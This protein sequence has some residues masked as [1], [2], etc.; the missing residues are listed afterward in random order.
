MKTAFNRYFNADEPLS[1]HT[2]FEAGYHA[3]PNYLWAGFAL[4]MI[5]MFV[6]LLI[7]S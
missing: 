1:V 6:L 2:A 5:S 3:A 4:G 7:V